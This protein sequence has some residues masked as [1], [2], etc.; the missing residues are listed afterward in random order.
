MPP[1]NFNIFSM[2]I[3]GIF[4]GW[5]ST[6]VMSISEDLIKKTIPNN[7]SRIILVIISFI[8]LM[9]LTLTMFLFII[10]YNSVLF[11]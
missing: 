3:L 5:A 7:S 10:I 9:I 6:L 8:L 1:I 2:M 4:S 11:W